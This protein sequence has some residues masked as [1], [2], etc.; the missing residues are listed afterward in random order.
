MYP[1]STLTPGTRSDEVR[2]L[3]E[4]LIKQ[5]ISIPAGAT[6]YYGDQ[7]KAAVAEWQKRNG[8]QAGADAGYWGPKS[9]A[10]AS[11]PT[12]NNNSVVNNTPVVKAPDDPSNMYRTDV[13]NTLNTNYKP[14]PP[15]AEEKQTLAEATASHPTLAPLVKRYGTYEEA[16]AAHGGDA[17]QMTDQ[18]GQPFSQADQTQ[19]MNDAGLALDPYYAAAT[20]KDTADTESR[21]ASD[22]QAYND[23]TKTAA[24]NFQ[25]DKTAQDQTAAT[26]GVLF[27]GGRVQKLNNLK[28]TYDVEGASKLAALTNKIGQTA[29]DYQYAY[30]NENAGKL[31]RYYTAGSNTYNPNV[32]TGG[33]VSSGLSSIYNPSAFNFQGTNINAAKAAKQARAAGLLWNKANKLTG[34]NTTY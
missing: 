2:K 24:T 11:N 26:N 3:Q 27:S 15:T 10:V 29:N 17:T 18:Y 32:A 19:A 16:L 8:V 6:G 25:A 4:F 34:A 28:N 20:Q 13:A 7:T 12:V 33:V 23:Y 21:L 14:A 31:S 5:N 30:G 1:T 9:V 22:T